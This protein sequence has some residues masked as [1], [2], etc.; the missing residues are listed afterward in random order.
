MEII[1]Y[2][3]AH[4]LAGDLLEKPNVALTVTHGEDEYVIDS[5]QRKFTCAN[6]DDRTMYLTLNLRFGGYGNLKR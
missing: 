2:T 3:T 4:E 6:E 5:I 1:A